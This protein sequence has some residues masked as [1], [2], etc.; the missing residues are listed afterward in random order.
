MGTF[1]VGSKPQFVAFDGTNVW[2]TNQ[3]SNSVTK[4]RACDGE[5]LGTFPTGGLPVGI[6]FDGANVWTAN[7]HH[8]PSLVHVVVSH[9]SRGSR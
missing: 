7:T 5:V 1:P 6:A 8:T 2:I 4:L 3:G 9:E